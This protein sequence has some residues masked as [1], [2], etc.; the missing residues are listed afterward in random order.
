M[1][2]FFESQVTESDLTVK[3]IEHLMANIDRYYNARF[4]LYGFYLAMISAVLTLYFS[5]QNN[6]PRNLFILA[7]IIGQLVVFL[8]II[9]SLQIQGNYSTLNLIFNKVDFI[10]KLSGIG[11][12]LR[13]EWY[14]TPVKW[15]FALPLA[16]MFVAN[17][18]MFIFGMNIMERSVA[19]IS[20]TT[21]SVITALVIAV[22]IDL[23]FFS[24]CYSDRIQLFQ[25]DHTI[26][27]QTTGRQR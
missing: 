21:F 22:Y 10:A 11:D 12:Q 26:I 3:F 19:W 18:V 5:N 1:G 17:I 9:I 7:S 15:P 8:Q 4:I 25:K 20:W 27:D 16:M 23:C 2:K 13:A 14:F 6:R 24:K